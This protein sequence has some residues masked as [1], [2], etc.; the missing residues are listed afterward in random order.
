MKKLFIGGHWVDTGKYMD[1]QSPYDGTHVETICTA[2]ADLTREAIDSAFEARD[3]MKHLSAAR[4]GKILDNVAALIER[5]KEEIAALITAE[6]G[7]G[8]VFSRG[9]ASRTVE[10]FKFAA[11]E[12][13]RLSGELVPYDASESGTNR[14]GYYKRYPIGVI[15]AITPFN[16]PLNLVAHKVGPAIAA[17]CPIVLKP[18]SS[19]PLTAHKLVELLL[20]A[21]LPANGINLVVGSGSVVGNV[22]VESDKIAMITFTGSP[23]VGLDIKAKAG[24]KKVTLELGSN[25]AAVIHEDAD[26]RYAVPKC[27]TGAFAN[28]GQVCISIQRIYVH[29]SR[30]DEFRTLFIDAVKSSR[31]G[32]PKDEKT[33]VGPM[34][35]EKEAARA[36][37]WVK[38]AVAQGAKLT[39]GGGR[40]GTLLEATVL[41]ETNEKMTV[42]REE[43]FAPVV[44]L[45]KYKTLD[46]VIE[47]VNDSQFGLQAGIFT[48]NIHNAFKAIDRFEVGGVMIN[49]M[50]TF[51]VDQMP[52][53][54]LKLSGT[55]REGPK[56]AVEEMTEIKTV[57]FNLN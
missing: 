1:V 49:D 14:F 8:L 6:A 2:S 36:E 45:M 5:D 44:C 29:E 54:G 17:G 3:T 24:I 42:V 47:R 23:A 22:M 48:N 19:T 13:R 25:S 18:A 32:D 26:V 9:E 10:N 56:F 33:L 55:G 52:Y 51:R 50:P 20:E 40:K 16:F 15:G 41:E 21:G 12:A 35:D 46:E 57:M 11:D 30:Y 34:I 4:R 53:G 38:D 7:K 28:S 39:V 27:V 43:L 37:Q 31:C